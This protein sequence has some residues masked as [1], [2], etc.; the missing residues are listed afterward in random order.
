MLYEGKMMNSKSKKNGGERER[1]R[2]EKYMNRLDK[3]KFRYLFFIFV[4][5]CF[6]Y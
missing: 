4:L 6:I 1:N 3:E 5:F 2:E